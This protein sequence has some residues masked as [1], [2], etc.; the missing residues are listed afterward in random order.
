MVRGN[1]GGRFDEALAGRAAMY[2]EGRDPHEQ[3]EVA[4]CQKYALIEADTPDPADLRVLGAAVATVRALAREGNLLLALDRVTARWWSPA[5]LHALA[6]DRPFDVDEHAQVVVEAIERTPGAGHLVRSR[7]LEKFARPDVG[8]R[9]PRRETS[10]ISELVRDVAR[11]LAEGHEVHPGDR[12]RVPDLPPLTLVPRTEDCLQDAPA[13]SAPLYE[14]RDLLPNGP[15]PDLTAL[16]AALRPK[17]R[18]K[19]LK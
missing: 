1:D 12:L 8:G 11:L 3:H 16:L 4:R 17:P 9:A 5:E 14:L 13:A 18:L 7:G 2:L 10:S 19:V 15:G 6:V